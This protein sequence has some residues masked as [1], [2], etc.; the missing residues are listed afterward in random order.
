VVLGIAV[1]QAWRP[2]LP[3]APRKDPIARAHGWDQLAAVVDSMAGDSFVGTRAF[4]ADSG[5]VATR[6]LAAER[7]Q[8]ASELSYHL[9][10]HPHVFSL[11]IAGRANQYDLWPT[12]YSEI[13]EGDA[14]VA[15]FDA[16]PDGD[17]RAAIVASWF[18][19]SREGPVIALKRG[20][21]EVAHRKIWLFR[22]AHAVPRD[23]GAVDI[24]G[25]NR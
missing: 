13:N 1:L 6:W 22:R 4:A 23:T 12:P 10:E 7:Y 17:A 24:R 19:E 15:S 11:N 25:R 18:R 3:L 8:D 16:N 5:G 9:P 14:L 21:G 20:S 2:L